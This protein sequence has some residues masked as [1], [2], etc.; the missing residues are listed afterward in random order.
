MKPGLHKAVHVV[1]H[2]QLSMRVIIIAFCLIILSGCIPNGKGKVD[3][4]SS[5]NVS[6]KVSAFNDTSRNGLSNSE[7]ISKAVGS[8]WVSEEDSAYSL[9]LHF[10]G[11]KTVF[12]SYSPECLFVFPFSVNDESMNIYWDV[13][14]DTKYNFDIVKAVHKIDPK[15]IGKRFMTLR[16]VNDTTLAVEYPNNTIRETIN[17]VGRNR[18]FLPDSFKRVRIGQEYQY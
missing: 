10:E 12:L 13:N 11:K 17:S 6:D 5:K 1:G 4:I 16:L 3:P 8:V 2:L 18:L 14:I 7:F 15:F 9:A